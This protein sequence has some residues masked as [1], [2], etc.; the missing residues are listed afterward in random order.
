MSTK[1]TQHEVRADVVLPMSAD[2][3][4]ERLETRLHGGR[5][6]DAIEAAVPVR[7]VV[8]PSREMRVPGKEVR[9]EVL[10]P[11][12]HGN[13]LVYPLHWQAVG[14]GAAAYPALEANI[15]IT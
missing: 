11:H 9:G 13:S 6:G 4:R 2:E 5:H 3:A 14:V 12:E 15:A 7:L 1:S 8:G 10:P